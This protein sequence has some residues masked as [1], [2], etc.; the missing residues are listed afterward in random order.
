MVK[1][2][3]SRGTE[4]R[5][6]SLAYLLDGMTHPGELYECLDGDAVQC[7][8]CG[9]RCLIREGRRGI[10]QVRFNKGGALYVPH[11]YA[12]GSQVDPVEKKPFFHLLPGSNAL[13]FGMLGCDFHCGYCQNWLTS[14]A[15]RDPAAGVAPQPISAAEIGSLADKHG[16]KLV[17]SSYNEPLITSEWAVDV[18]QEARKRGMRCAYVS[19]G[20][21][22][23]V[24]VNGGNPQEIN[25]GLDAIH[26]KI[27]W[28]KDG[29]KIAFG[30]T[31][32]GE[33]ELWL[34]EDFLPLVKR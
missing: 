8:A 13:T 22:W 21:L 34:M 19:N 26:L 29:K 27:D 2:P 17:V 23:T 11:G 28:S 3:A 10:C 25:T 5:E 4:R 18:F 15:L 33:H 31:Q 30:A 12:A 32:G 14:Q 9:H 7:V 20:K 24:A 1:V 6:T 16:A